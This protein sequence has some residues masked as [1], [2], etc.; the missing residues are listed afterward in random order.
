[1]YEKSSA[2]L[3][4]RGLSAG[5]FAHGVRGPVVTFDSLKRAKGPG[6]TVCYSRPEPKAQLDGHSL[7]VGFS[8]HAVERLAERQTRWPPYPAAHDAFYLLERSTSFEVDASPAFSF[9]VRVDPVGRR[10]ELAAELLGHVPAGDVY[11]RVGWCPAVVEGGFLKAKT[12]IHPGGRGTPEH[13]L[14]PREMRERAERPHASLDPEAV[15]VLR[16]LHGHGVPQV[17]V[18]R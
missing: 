14:L 18:A 8:G 1:L 7:T 15:E 16:W 17:R 10:Y 13:S 6:G 9:W 5:L 4:M 12:L 11:C 3:V 2:R